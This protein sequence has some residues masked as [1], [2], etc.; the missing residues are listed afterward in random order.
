M[1][2]EDFAGLGSAPIPATTEFSEGVLVLVGQYSPLEIGKITLEIHIILRHQR[3]T[4][5]LA[6]KSPITDYGS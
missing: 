5:R 6:W 3:C 4:A 1:H 2:T